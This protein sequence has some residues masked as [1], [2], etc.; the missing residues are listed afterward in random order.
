MHS[1]FDSAPADTPVPISFVTPAMCQSA[2][3]ALPA[4]AKQF[5][6]ANA[7]T[8]KPGQ[9]LAVPGTD[10]TIAHVLFGLEEEGSKTFDPFRPG[11][12]TGLLPPGTYRFASKPHD[13]RLAALAFA[14]AN[15]RFR[16]YRKA[17]PTEVKLALS[18]SADA[19]EL[20]RIADA[21]SLARDLVNTPAN[22]MGPEELAESARQVG[23]VP[24][25]F[26]NQ[27]DD[28]KPLRGFVHPKNCPICACF[29][30]R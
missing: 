4:L 11:Q 5:A 27:V 2:I 1:T 22:D 28:S 17:E 16:R 10:G 29:S 21:A 3:D 13:E 26:L 24:G 14:L 6:A 8:G 9:C 18:N 12:L 19:Y 15:Y 7:F 23:F 25:P 20:S 30:P